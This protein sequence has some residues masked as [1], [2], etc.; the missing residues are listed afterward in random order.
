MEHQDYDA[1]NRIQDSIARNFDHLVGPASIEGRLSSSNKDNE[2]SIE[3]PKPFHSEAQ[4]LRIVSLDGLR[5]IAALVVLVFHCLNV[6]QTPF[7]DAKSVEGHL[8]TFA[9]VLSYTPLRVFWVGPEAVLVFFALSGF[10]LSRPYLRGVRS[11]KPRIF[12]SRRFIRLYL[13]LFGSAALALVL[14]L[15]PRHIYPG[16]STWLIESAAPVNALNTAVTLGLVAGNRSNL[17]GV[18]WSL[19]WEVVFSLML[20][21]L[22]YLYTKVPLR[23]IMLLLLSIAVSTVA[24]GLLIGSSE[25]V[26]GAFFYLPIFAMGIA[27]AAMEDSIRVHV[28]RWGPFRSA[29]FLLVGVSC[30]TATWPMKWLIATGHI[31]S[32]QATAYLTRILMLIGVG[33]L[34]TS[35]L[36]SESVAGALSRRPVQW[37]G[38]RSYS[39]YLIHAPIILALAYTFKMT[40]APL[41]FCAMAVA[42][43]L[44]AS[45]VFFRAFEK[46]TLNFLSSRLKG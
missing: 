41:W 16:Q 25:S 10:V 37:L 1:S 4:S 32:G 6:S 11:L 33:I 45:E 44:L 12:Y 23:P 35:A 43:C 27:L 17:N 31:G 29:V 19:Q 9:S 14:L 46:P 26:H 13:P 40:G 38:Q 34:M 42:A 20:P 18:Y 28:G 21:L 30:L 3:P 39:L 22:L 8:P 24:P 36:G 7:A 5:G 2:T 15:I